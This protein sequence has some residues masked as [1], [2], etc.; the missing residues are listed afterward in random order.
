MILD[1]LMKYFL[2]N[3]LIIKFIILVIFLWN[4]QKYLN[5][6]IKVL[7]NYFNYISDNDINHNII[8]KKDYEK[9]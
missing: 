7:K 1:L 2:I 9:K 5:I 6:S 4:N 8:I 3:I